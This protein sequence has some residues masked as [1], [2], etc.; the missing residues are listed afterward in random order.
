[1]A[2]L[3][4]VA[5]SL[6]RLSLVDLGTDTL[7]SSMYLLYF[8]M[9]YP[10]FISMRVK[11]DL[12]L[13][14]KL[15]LACVISHLCHEHNS[16]EFRV[17]ASSTTFGHKSCICDTIDSCRLFLH[18]VSSHHYLYQQGIHRLEAENRSEKSE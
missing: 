10:S 2:V 12:K 16:S 9:W 8:L 13:H 14:S 17:F 4:R 15:W 3:E 7:G 11:D 6:L 1:M 18:R 5:E